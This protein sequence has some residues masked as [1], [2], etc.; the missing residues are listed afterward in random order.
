[1]TTRLGI[2]LE[3]RRNA[4]K[5]RL[6]VEV[7]KCMRDLFVVWVLEFLQKRCLKLLK[8]RE[9]LAPERGSRQFCGGVSRLIRCK[10][11]QQTVIRVCGLLSHTLIVRTLFG[12]QKINK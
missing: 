1:M 8:Q 4:E 2:K 9:R 12:E 7:C 3:R 11:G 10:K 6:F 5:K